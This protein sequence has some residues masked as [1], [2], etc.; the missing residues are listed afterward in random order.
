TDEGIETNIVTVTHDTKKILGVTTVVVHDV[1]Y[2]GG[3]LKEDTLDWYA[4]DKGSNVWY[5]GE[6]TRTYEGGEVTGIEGSW[7]AGLEGG[8]PGII[9]KGNPQVN[10]VY[11]QE[12]SPGLVE[13]GAKVLALNQ[14]VTVPYGSFTGCVQTGE[15][16]P[17]EPETVDTFDQKFYAPGIGFIV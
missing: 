11:R 15:F 8:K 7:E 17:L 12:F 16:T 6:L 5:F 1:V 9:M 3:E 10:D 2:R 14:S 13:D 4:Q